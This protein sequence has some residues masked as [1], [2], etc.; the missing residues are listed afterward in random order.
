MFGFLKGVGDA[1]KSG[2]RAGRVVKVLQQVIGRP[3]S[4]AE[5]EVFKNFHDRMDYSERVS[6]GLIA[7]DYFYFL[8]N[9]EEHPSGMSSPNMKA[10]AKERMIE[11]V[12]G[13]LGWG[14]LLLGEG[15]NSTEDIAT[16]V[17][18]LRKHA[19]LD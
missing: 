11:V 4:V 18:F 17:R 3:L 6:D 9:G 12:Q 19:G 7:L 16:Q 10:D 14:T 5:R 8:L 1:I 13:A 2:Q 15:M